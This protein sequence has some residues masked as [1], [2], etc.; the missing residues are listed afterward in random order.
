[1]TTDLLELP[2]GEVVVPTLPDLYE[3]VNGEIVECPP[4]STYSV[5][6]AHL[7]NDLMRT[8]LAAQPLGRTRVE[9]PFLI[10]VHG[11]EGRVRLPDLAFVSY[12][13]WPRNRPIPRTGHGLAV[14]PELVVE[15][16]SPNDKV[17]ELMTKTAEYLAAGARQVWQILPLN[18]LL[19]V[20]DSPT[21]TRGFRDTDTISGDTVLTGFTFRLADVLP[22]PEP[23]EANGEA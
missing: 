7:L 6:V 14:V 10:P 23:E 1:M 11:D 16:I 17:K 12:D 5:E 3:V 9:Y 2:L 22:E 21:Q 13:R 8:F 15:V 4:M 20:Y 18:R 19:Y